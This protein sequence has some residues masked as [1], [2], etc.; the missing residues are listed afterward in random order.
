MLF[1]KL[2]PIVLF[3][4][5]TA[6]LQ[7]QDIHYTQFHH[8]SFNTNPALTGIFKGDSRIFSQFRQQWKNVPVD[9]L[10]FTGAY[11]GKIKRKSFPDKRTIGYGINLNYDRAGFSRLSQLGIGFN[12]NYILKLREGNYISA[13]LNVGFAQRFF[14]VDG[15][16]FDNQYQ[17]NMFDASIP[18]D[19]DLSNT[20]FLYFD[21]GAGVNY[22]WQSDND[23]RS[24]LDIGVG[25]FHLNR[26][27]QMF[28]ETN[29][30]TS[31]L[32]VR[33]SP[34]L[35]GHLKIH[36][37]VDLIGRLTYQNQGPY[38]ELVFG[39]AIKF[40]LNKKRGQQIAFEVGGMFRNA[41]VWDA[42]SPYLRVDYNAF[43]AGIT[44]DVNI[45]PFDIATKSLGGPEVYLS[46]RFLSVEPTG[47]L[48]TCRIF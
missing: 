17:S 5:L 36:S 15:L 43:T 24:K 34:Y 25:L 11:E 6:C 9:Y 37:L 1:K 22:H 20:S 21:L 23:G 3:L 8:S 30:E 14:N 48:K 40:Y 10:T 42:V 12:G 16:T 31:K 46:Y 28:L 27:K 4:L 41:N 45:S 2:K 13:G 39:P 19:E 33:L 38:N 18:I 26:P 35:L 32:D 47:K 44:Y 29:N 7:A